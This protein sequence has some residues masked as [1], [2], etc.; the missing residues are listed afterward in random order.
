MVRKRF[1]LQTTAPS[2]S[3]APAVGATAPDTA[4]RAL[5]VGLFDRMFGGGQ[6]RTAGVPNRARTW[7]G[8]GMVSRARTARKTAHGHYSPLF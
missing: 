6:V 7:F 2:P 8:Y 3:A 5:M 4:T 1:A